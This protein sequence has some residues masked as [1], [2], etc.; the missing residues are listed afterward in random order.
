MPDSLDDIIDAVDE[1]ASGPA[2]ASGDSGS[3]QQHNLRDLIA[4]EKHRG[5][6]SAVET[7][8]RGLR[9]NKFVPPGSV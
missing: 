1:V 2:S 3:I 8:R 4:F 9:F 5:G 6:S 7:T